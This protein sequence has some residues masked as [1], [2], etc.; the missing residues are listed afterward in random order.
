M[1]VLLDGYW[2][3]NGPPSGRNVLRSI[4]LTWARSFDDELHLLVPGGTREDGPDA[5]LIHPVSASRHPI[6]TTVTAPRMIRQIKPDASLSH[7]FGIRAPNSHCFV[8]DMIFK[9]HA[10]WFTLAERAYL[11]SSLISL[12][13]SRLLT[14][15]KAEARRIRQ[16]TGRA[17]QPVG[18]GP[19]AALTSAVPTP[20]AWSKSLRT[21]SLTVGR[22]NVRKNLSTTIDMHLKADVAS[23]DCPLVVVG[24]ADGKTAALSQKARRAVKSGSVIFAGHVSDA[25]LAWL[26]QE[27]SWS[28]C[29]SLD[30]GFGMPV[31]EARSFGRPVVASDI[32]A[33]AENLQHDAGS[34][35]VDPIDTR[36]IVRALQTIATSAS[37]RPFTLPYT[38]EDVVANIRAHLLERT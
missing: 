28:T 34:L 23:P 10:D 27:C 12:R 11:E 16:V 2:W 8:H 37:A 22:L 32:P 6:L 7:T 33:F 24:A 5:L 18:L 21:F 29:L 4:V 25:E 20:P 35:L 31:V 38:W 36:A 30:E 17:A 14:S 26:Y 3:N 13:S 9:T 15:S 1:K 19:S